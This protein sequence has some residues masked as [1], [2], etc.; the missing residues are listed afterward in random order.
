MAAIND[1]LG[2]PTPANLQSL[3]QNPYAPQT[4][5]TVGTSPTNPAAPA[6]STKTD[7]KVTADSGAVTKESIA[8]L[9]KQTNL[10]TN[11]LDKLLNTCGRMNDNYRYLVLNWLVNGYDVGNV[12]YWINQQ[13]TPAVFNSLDASEKTFINDLQ[14]LVSG[15]DPSLLALLKKTPAW[16]KGHFD[17]IGYFGVTHGVNANLQPANPMTG[18]S[19]QAGT[20]L[21]ERALNS[22]NPDATKNLEDFLNKV[23]THSYL[24]IP[25]GAFGTLQKIISS[26][27]AVLVAFEKL[28]RDIYQGCIDLIQKLY[29]IVNGLIVNIERYMLSMINQYIIPLDLLCLII[30]ALQSFLGDVNFFSSLFNQSASISKYFNNFQSFIN[31]NVQLVSNPL[32]T[33]QKYFTP[34]INQ[35]INLVNQVGANPNQALSTMLNNYGYHYALNAVQ[36]DLAAA[37]VNK[38]GA[39]YTAITPLGNFLNSQVASQ[40]GIAPQYPQTPATIGPSIYQGPNGIATYA[41]GAP[42]DPKTVKQS[43]ISNIADPFKV[44]TNSLSGI[45]SNFQK[46]LGGLGTSLT[47]LG[48]AVNQ[49]A[50]EAGQ[51]IQSAAVNAGAAINNSTDVITGKSH[52]QPPI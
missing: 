48:T 15:K 1:L 11:E 28:I 50:T 49:G 5:P 18:P 36:G 32:S 19:K 44:I 6:A 8:A 3:S 47:D 42:V 41:N 52:Y 35:I 2:I 45:A 33:V 24:S 34:E 9:E 14:T 12:V 39:Q 20:S 29:A 40:I 25:K 7:N 23:R 27:N 30:A 46:D 43:L 51:S 10:S 17:D 26:L 31:T 22:T 16:E 13:H 38:Y 37:V 4:N 21:F